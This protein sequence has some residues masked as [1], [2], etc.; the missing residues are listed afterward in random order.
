M[1]DLILRAIL[2]VLGFVF[3]TSGRHALAAEPAPRTLATICGARPVPAHVLA[4]TIRI[5]GEAVALIRPYV[6]ASDESQRQR[7]RRLALEMA[8]LGADYPYAFPGAPFPA[9]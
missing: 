9:A 1:R 6:L 3:P 4:R 7:E 2:R 5:P 8:A